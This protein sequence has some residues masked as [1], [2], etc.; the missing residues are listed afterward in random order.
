VTPI[1]AYDISVPTSF[2]SIISIFS[3]SIRAIEESY[4]IA[5]FQHRL[6]ADFDPATRTA[7]QTSLHFQIHLCVFSARGIDLR[8]RG[9]GVLGRGLVAERRHLQLADTAYRRIIRKRRRRFRSRHLMLHSISLI[10]SIP[11]HLPTLIKLVPATSA[12]NP[13]V[14]NFIFAIVCKERK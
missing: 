10:H 9:I 4:A 11:S 7:C 13:S 8:E 6:L 1:T 5:N 14:K 12:G 2:C 3:R